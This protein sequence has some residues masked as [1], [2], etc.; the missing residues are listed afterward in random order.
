M[1]LARWRRTKNW[2]RNFCDIDLFIHLISRTNKMA[3]DQLLNKTMEYACEQQQCFYEFLSECFAYQP[4]EHK[5]LKRN[6]GYAIYGPPIDNND[7]RNS[8]TESIT[9]STIE[10]TTENNTT[11][12]TDNTGEIIPLLAS[13]EANNI[14]SQLE[15]FENEDPDIAD[16]LDYNEKQKAVIDK[17]Y[18]KICDC[19][20]EKD[21][22]QP[23]YFGI[24][25]NV[26]IICSKTD[27]KPKEEETQVDRQDNDVKE[28]DNLPI[29]AIPIFTIR[30][31]TRKQSTT[32]KAARNK[33]NEPTEDETSYDVW[34]IDT[35]ARVYKTWLGYKNNNNLPEC[36]MVLPKD[37]CYQKDENYPATEDYST[38]LLE[39]VESPACKWTAKL[40]N[41]MDIASTVL[42]IGGM[43]LCVASMFTPLAPIAVAGL[44]TTGATGAWSIGRSSQHL[45]DRSMHEESIGL[46][47]KEA[48]PH[49]IGLAGSATGLGVIGGSAAISAA[50]ARGMT[51]NIVARSA[52]NTVQG[53]SIFFNGVG[54]AYQGYCII[55]K[56]RTEE[57]ISIADTLSFVTHAMFFAGSVVKI[58]F[59][60]DIIESTQGRIIDDY[61]ENLRNKNFRKKFNRA[62]RRANANNTNKISENAEVI[63]YI[64]HRQQL[65]SFTQSATANTRMSN[66]NSYNVV[67]SFTNGK[68]TVNGITLIDPLEYVLCLIKAG[69][70]TET[71]QRDQDQSRNDA[72]DNIVEQSMKMFAELLKKF[73]KS[74]NCSSS[75]RLPDFEPLIREIS[76][77]NINEEYIKKLFHIAVTLIGRSRDMNHFLLLIMTFLWQYCKAN[78]KQWN[79][80]TYLRVHSNSGSS[81]LRKIIIAVSEAVEM[82]SDNLMIASLM[83]VEARL[84]Q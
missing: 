30:K 36:T 6:I 47:N 21:N 14:N 40:C 77:M 79:I 31:S 50:A 42:G 76:S 3:T 48:F 84:R 4:D 44:V 17:I 24:I 69:I 60:G 55:D 37:G 62:K 15:N 25:Y 16:T 43:G 68:L 63:R 58:Q 83:Y 64:R 59:A 73:C 51:V 13:M 11:D 54:V 56:Y 46:L 38:V 52:F 20:L 71:T 78:L 26:A 28:E 27:V 7:T 57:T 74:N 35:S 65:P 72:N 82:I 23:I 75:T 49:W 39:I 81:V 61:S 45:I 10:I 32:T 8:T 9:E 41:G 29:L 80:I 12:T 66:K 70:F 1:L 34:Y 67:W 19:V 5:Y 33:G 53:S 18:S 2:S 22:P